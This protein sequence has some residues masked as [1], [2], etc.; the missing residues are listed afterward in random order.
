T[1]GLL[2][3][4]WVYSAQ[5]EPPGPIWSATF[6]AMAGAVSRVTAVAADNRAFMASSPFAAIDRPRQDELNPATLALG[7]A[8][9][10]FPDTLSAVRSTRQKVR[11]FLRSLCLPK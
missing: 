10:F 5:F 8:V 7:Y 1:V 2:A 11:L 3:A 6:P 4:E 9:V